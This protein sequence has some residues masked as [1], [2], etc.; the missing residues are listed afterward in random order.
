MAGPDSGADRLA[1]L[2][3]EERR[4]LL[5]GD[6]GRLADLAP[7]KQALAEAFARRPVPADSDASRLASLAR[8]NQA[9]LE[10]AADGLRSALRRVIEV[11]NLHRGRG[12]YGASG[13]RADSADSAGI[14]RRF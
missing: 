11:R 5:A 8:R 10:A 1:A 2:L 14:E 6:L 13:L 12:T 9:L 4:C 3:S 7:E